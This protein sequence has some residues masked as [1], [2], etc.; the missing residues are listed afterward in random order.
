MTTVT[1]H[2]AGRLTGM[3]H[4]GGGSELQRF[5]YSYDNS[6]RRTGVVEASG[7]RVTWTHDLARRLTREHPS[8]C[9]FA[10]TQDERGTNAYDIA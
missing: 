8:I 2:V 1:F 3:R 6:G 10:P 4:T 5:A 7:D 9:R